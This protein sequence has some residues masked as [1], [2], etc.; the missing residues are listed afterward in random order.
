MKTKFFRRC[1]MLLLAAVLASGAMKGQ[2]CCDSCLKLVF[3][4]DLNAGFFN[5]HN[6]IADSCNP[7]Y[8]LYADRTFIVSF[9]ENIL[10][11]PYKHRDSVIEA[12][13]TDIDTNMSIIREKFS[14][15]EEEF[16]LFHFNKMFPEDTTTD[17]YYNQLFSLYFDNYV[18]IEKVVTF[19]DTLDGV[20]C[21]FS[22]FPKR[23]CSENG[24]PGMGQNSDLATPKI[25]L[26]DIRGEQWGHYAIKAPMAWEVTQGSKNVYVGIFEN[27]Y[28][29]YKLKPFYQ[30]QTNYNDRMK[31]E[32]NP[33]T[34]QEI[35]DSRGDIPHDEIQKGNIASSNRNLIIGNVNHVQIIDEK[36]I[37][38][39]TDLHSWDNDHIERTI[40]IISG[41]NDSKGMC[42]IAPNSTIVEGGNYYRREFVKDFKEDKTF[43]KWVEKNK[44]TPINFYDLDL[45]NNPN[46]G[47]IK[48][49][50]AVCQSSSETP[51]VNPPQVLK[52]FKNGSFIIIGSGNGID[53]ISQPPYWGYVPEYIMFYGASNQ[54]PPAEKTNEENNDIR[55]DYIQSIMVSTVEGLGLPHNNINYLESPFLNNDFSCIDSDNLH[56]NPNFNFSK[57]NMKF[58]DPDFTIADFK[59]IKMYSFMDLV[60]PGGR[61]IGTS[62]DPDFTNIY[63]DK[64]GGT[65]YASCYVGGVIALMQSVD[66]TLNANI[67]SQDKK[68]NLIRRGYNIITFTAK[69]NHDIG[70]T[71]NN[72]SSSFNPN[73]GGLPSI[74]LETNYKIQ[75]FDPLRRS[76][77]MRMGFGLVD[78]YRAVANSIPARARYEYTS[79]YSITNNDCWLNPGT[80]NPRFI[81]FGGLIHEDVAGDDDEWMQAINSYYG[82]NLSSDL[83]NSN[84]TNDTLQ[85][86]L[87]GGRQFP[88]N[89]AGTTNLINN[90]HG[91]TLINGQNTTITVP[92]NIVAAIDGIVRQTNATK[93]DNKI[94]TT[95][96]GKILIT[97]YLEDV[98]LDGVIKMSDQEMHSWGETNKCTV[99]FA[100]G[101]EIYGNVDVYGKSLITVKDNA[102]L[103]IQP[104]GSINLKGDEDL[105]INSGQTIVLASGSKISSNGNQKIV[106]KSGGTLRLI[107]NTIGPPVNTDA[108][109]KV[110]LLCNV[111]VE[112]GGILDFAPNSYVITKNIIYKACTTA[113]TINYNKSIAIFPQRDDNKNVIA[114]TG[115]VILESKN[116]LNIVNRTAGVKP[117]AL[118][119]G[120]TLG[121]HANFF[122]EQ[123]DGDFYC[124]KIISDNNSIIEFK[125]GCNVIFFSDNAIREAGL[126]NHDIHG[127]I[128]IGSETV[129]KRLKLI[130]N[131]SNNSYSCNQISTPLV[132]SVFNIDKSSYY[133]FGN[134]DFENV[135][136]KINGR[137]VKNNND[138]P[139]SNEPNIF[140]CTFSH[141]AVK[142]QAFLQNASINSSIRDDVRDNRPIEFINY[143]KRSWIS[144]SSC[145]FQDKAIMEPW[146]QNDPLINYRVSGIYINN[147]VVYEIGNS[148]GQNRNSFKNLKNGVFSDLCLYVKVQGSDFE[149]CSTGVV[150]NL[151][152]IKVCDNTFTNDRAGVSLL[153]S[154]QWSIFANTFFGDKECVKMVNTEKQNFRGNL[155][156]HY[157]RAISV[158]NGT[159]Y[160]T[161]EYTSPDEQNIFNI[162]N[163]EFIMDNPN[164]NINNS[165][166]LT[167]S[168]DNGGSWKY[169]GD[170]SQTDIFLQNTG[171]GFMSTNKSLLKTQ[172]G[173]NKYAEFTNFFAYS[174]QLQLQLNNEFDYNFFNNLSNISNKMHN[175]L[176]AQPSNQSSKARDLSCEFE[177]PETGQCVSASGIVCPFGIYNYGNWAELPIGS[178]WIDST[179]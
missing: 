17:S 154:K 120:V 19:I 76:W 169:L 26:K 42:G 96:T 78:A 99:S 128:I 112:E 142:L 10:N 161:D 133:R 153:G 66:E 143:N 56:F 93:S 177:I 69:K 27:W 20:K 86:L 36:L 68:Y 14:E 23:L 116:T 67:P 147:S 18:E 146:L 82:W 30:N 16:G 55:K 94:L 170:D 81:H 110:K 39:G 28:E 125:D 85:I 135:H 121:S 126:V 80:T 4:H 131:A 34:A 45:D 41:L 60:V 51:P 151:S 172:C 61:N 171:R 111:E 24:N 145:S 79:S 106:V 140:N 29:M 15:L 119:G 52:L 35:Y 174:E 158:D 74:S 5:P 87:F 98:S 49:P 57:Y 118:F 168:T 163:N 13:W 108:T 178:S 124:G 9:Q 12:S 7:L 3:E 1:L 101:S 47:I 113:R 40:G 115:K 48:T 95:E 107:D 155:F 84:G 21:Y 105:D 122:V 136:F 176:C 62:I 129:N 100:N 149:N 6:V 65:S 173:Y 64:E 71:I 89:P 50:N 104:G 138:I 103:T 38:T 44:E 144:I 54:P 90:N 137:G 132:I 165:R 179:F 127:S 162:G 91:E 31:E 175:I 164:S 72:L 2:D 130:G 59:T 63:F 75:R 159:A 83:N 156:Q 43:N 148:L 117:I 58:P 109:T 32:N 22:G 46:N 152:A 102:T 160:L 88:T 150:D 97:G 92:D 8:P 77:A 11:L 157:F 139:Q 123:N 167:A 141:D 73:T 25:Y 134:T 114:G 37:T 53:L 33:P 70:Y 166:F